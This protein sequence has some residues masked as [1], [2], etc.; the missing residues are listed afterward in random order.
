MSTVADRRPIGAPAAAPA[1]RWARIRRPITNVVRK[2]LSLPTPLLCTWALIAVFC[3]IFGR[4]GQLH[5]ANFGTWSFD[6]AIYDQSFWQIAHG[7]GFTTVRGL[8]IWGH[9]INLV[10]YLYAPFYWLGAGP[11]FLMV[12]QAIVLGLGGL[13]AYLIARDRFRSEWIGCAFA[14]AFL[15]YAPI[16]FIAWANFHPEALVI[17]PLLFAWWFASRRAW[18]AYG[19]ALLLALSTREDTA[20]AVMMLGAVL[21][22]I[23]FTARRSARRSMW[24]AGWATLVIGAVWYA[25]CTRIV[26]PHFN[27][28]LDPFY[29]AMFYSEWGKD[30]PSVITTMV[31]N[32]GRVAEAA[33]KEDR[34]EFYKGL[35][36]PLGGLPLLGLPLLVMAAPQ[37]LASVTGSTEYARSIWYQYTSVMIAPIMIA[38]IEGTAWTVRRVSWRKVLALWLVVSTVVTNLTWS[39]S[40]I[41]DKYWFWIRNNPIKATMDRAVALIPPDAPVTATYTF[42]PHLSQRQRAYDWPNPFKPAYWGNEVTNDDG[43][44]ERW[45]PPLP[46]SDAVQYLVTLDIH[47]DDDNQPLLSRLIGRGG[48]FRVLLRENGVIVAERVR[49]SLQSPPTPVAVAE[50]PVTAVAEPAV[51]AVAEAP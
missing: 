23:G 50:P 45:V 25:V 17:T 44:V 42:L 13:P 34:L 22:A 10:A 11:S 8:P 5:H 15:G 43:F 35:L 39:P 33:V 47:V 16:Q 24:L 41:G 36:A 40:P 26:L 29:I 38:A 49:T 20:L 3:I 48:E 37:L 46:D 2:L 31:R 9:H 27:Y 21:V 4:L 51:T 14:F 32:P 6:M 18:R 7:R 28:G 12:S 30:M 1:G 19:I